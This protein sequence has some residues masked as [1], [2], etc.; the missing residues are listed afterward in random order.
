MKG[1]M[2]TAPIRLTIMPASMA[3]RLAASNVTNTTNAFLKTLSLAAP[4]N[5]V[6]KNGANRRSRSSV[7]WLG[8]LMDRSLSRLSVQ[9]GSRQDRP[10]ANRVHRKGARPAKAGQDD[11]RAIGFRQRHAAEN[12]HE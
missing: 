1:R 6:Q 8:A 12:A 11:R 3:R 2:N 7:N 4:R 9:P 5:C 10:V